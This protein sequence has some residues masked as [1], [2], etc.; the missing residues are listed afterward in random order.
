[1]KGRRKQLPP[2][3][4]HRKLK[5]MEKATTFFLFQERRK[6]LPPPKSRFVRLMAGVES[7]DFLFSLRYCTCVIGR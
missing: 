5:E 6:P 7:F 1:M 3:F 2:A 4:H